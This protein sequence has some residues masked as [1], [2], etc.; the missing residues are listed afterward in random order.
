MNCIYIRIEY[1]R[2]LSSLSRL[3]NNEV[4]EHNLQLS[5]DGQCVIFPVL[6][7][8]LGNEKFNDTQD[9]LYSVNLTNE[10]I[11]HLGKDF[12]GGVYILGQLGTSVQ[13]YYTQQ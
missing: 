10:N 4:L 5:T 13:I 11:E 12:D 6:P 9:R 7:L 2:N 1:L 3:T 8:S